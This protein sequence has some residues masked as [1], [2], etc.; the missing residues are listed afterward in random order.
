MEYQDG[1]FG[2]HW[3]IIVAIPSINQTQGK[4]YMQMWWNY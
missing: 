3:S 1:T 2:L 4:K